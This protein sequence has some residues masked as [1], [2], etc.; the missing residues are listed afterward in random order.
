M[1]PG[2]LTRRSMNFRQHWRTEGIEEVDYT[3]RI[4]LALL[5]ELMEREHHDYV[6]DALR[7]PSDDA[8]EA[9]Q[10]AAR[11]PSI[12]AMLADAELLRMSVEW[13]DRD[14][15]MAWLGDGPP[16]ERPGYVINTVRFEG[17]EADMLLLSGRARR[18]EQPVR[19]QDV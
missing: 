4:P 5:R 3:L 13:Y 11:W 1:R 19:Y 15:L 16:A 14:L 12:A 9:A 8:Y 7:H 10:R 6:E 17:C 18:A 2:Q